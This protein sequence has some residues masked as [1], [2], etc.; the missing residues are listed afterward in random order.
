[1]FLYGWLGWLKYRD[2]NSLTIHYGTT[3]DAPVAYQYWASN[4][5]Q[6]KTSYL[7]ST[8]IYVRLR[9][10]FFMTDKFT[11]VYTAVKHVSNGNYKKTQYAHKNYQIDMNI[12]YINIHIYYINYFYI[13]YIY[14]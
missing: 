11:F 9:G 3:S 14:L 5:T 12:Y 10:V 13:Y 1:M 4:L 2:V 7:T 6:I 8:G